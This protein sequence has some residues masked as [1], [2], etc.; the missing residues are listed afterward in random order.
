MVATYDG[1]YPGGVQ[2]GYMLSA[3]TTIAETISIGGANHITLT[4]AGVPASLRILLADTVT[5]ADGSKYDLVD[6]GAHNFFVEALDPDGNVIVEHARRGVTTSRSTT[7]YATGTA[8]FTV[9]PTFVGQAT[10]GNLW[11]TEVYANKI[12]KITP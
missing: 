4:L 5:V 1:A 10:H 9:T 2:S 3:A 12:G 6:A 8:S 7:T 11:F